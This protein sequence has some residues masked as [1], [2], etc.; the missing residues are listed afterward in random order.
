MTNFEKTYVSTNNKIGAPDYDHEF[1][2]RL[3]EALMV[4]APEL[5]T[6]S[7]ALM[8]GS[9]INKLVLR[10]KELP[11]CNIYRGT[12]TRRCSPTF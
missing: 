1:I 6:I 2:S 8:V 12:Q 7:Y 3:R 4:N 11:G 5:N 9:T 10:A